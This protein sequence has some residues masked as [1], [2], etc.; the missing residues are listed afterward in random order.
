MKESNP[1]E[2]AEY[3]VAQGIDHKLAFEWWVL[4]RLKKQDR[5]IA[6]VNKQ[7]HKTTHKFGIQVPKTVLEAIQI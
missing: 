2:V 1:T 7:Y 4:F 3:A 5:I 6:N